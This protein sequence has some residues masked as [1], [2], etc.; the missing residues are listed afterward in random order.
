MI[1]L[2]YFIDAFGWRFFERYVDRYPFLSRFVREGIAQDHISVSIDNSSSC[3]DDQ[4]V[5]GGGA[6]TAFMSGFT[7]S[8]LLTGS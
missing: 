7:M 5:A 3:D 2:S 6:D 1:L 4:H 8:R